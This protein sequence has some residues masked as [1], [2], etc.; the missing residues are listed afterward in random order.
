[1]KILSKLQERW[2]AIWK[3]NLKIPAGI[4]GLIMAE[5][6]ANDYFEINY[7]AT[8]LMDVKHNDRILEVGFGPGVAIHDM[9]DRAPN[10]YI[11]GIDYSGAMVARAMLRNFNHMLKGRVNLQLASVCER[12][13]S[14]PTQFNK[15]V[16]INNVMY[17]AKPVAALKR[18]KKLLVPGGSLNLVIQRSEKRIKSGSCTD[19]IQK[20]IHYLQEAGYSNI[21]VIV[22]PIVERKRSGKAFINSGILIQGFNM[23]AMEQPLESNSTLELVREEKLA[24]VS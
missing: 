8:A 18:L 13:P 1:M 24:H 16:A 5:H 11:A 12:L 6:L 22:N 21:N 2:K 10:G 20:Y 7:W 19:E 4:W 3:R 17:W 23:I 14:F 15:I 9:A